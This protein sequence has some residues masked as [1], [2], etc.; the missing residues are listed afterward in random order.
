VRI[1]KRD[2]DATDGTASP[3]NPNVP[4]SRSKQTLHEYTRT[5][6]VTLQP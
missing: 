5:D 4:I 6:P 1:V 3:R 2:T